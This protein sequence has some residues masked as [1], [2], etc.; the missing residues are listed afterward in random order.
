MQRLLNPSRRQVL[1]LSGAATAGILLATR[2][3]Q[4]AGAAGPVYKRKSIDALTSAELDAYKHAIKIVMDRGVGA[5][6]R[7]DGYVWQA[8]LHNDDTRL[9]GDGTTGRCDHNSE[10]F[11]PWHRVHIRGLEL[12][13]R[14]TDPPRTAD[15]FVPYWD[16]TKPSS[17]TRLPKAFEDPTSPLFMPGDRPTTGSPVLWDAADVATKVQERDW[18]TFAGKARTPTSLPSTGPFERGP[19]NGMHG[20]I[21]F[22][23]ADPSTAADDPIYWS[24]HCFIDLVWA[25]WQRL[26]TSPTSPQP[27][28]DGGAKL[29][30]EPQTPTV[31]ETASTREM[32]YE[33]DYN[34]TAADGPV[35]PPSP[36]AAATPTRRATTVV[37]E[38]EAA[39]T[40]QPEAVAQTPAKGRVVL[41]DLVARPD[42]GYQLSVFLHPASSPFDS[43]PEGERQKYLVETMTIL[44]GH[45]HPEKFDAY[46][47]ISNAAAKLGGAPWQVTVTAT[48]LPARG[49]AGAA[50]PESVTRFGST[51][52]VFRTIEIEER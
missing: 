49:V 40:V 6:D 2:L 34:F 24:F 22:T 25:R 4:Q 8:R 7:Q 36:V 46:V 51:R 47:D 42:A 48:P 30:L 52:E 33:Y 15:L 21:G 1:T 19:H 5:P 20:R 27:Y 18:N 31:A 26:H 14:A 35:P 11:L 9:K 32:G 41:R 28:M 43:L 17:G 12:I 45:H 16:W 44:K 39:V 23:M 38:K 10:R 37:A 29:W 3:P 13:L 50:R